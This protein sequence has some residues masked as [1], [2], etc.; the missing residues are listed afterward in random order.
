MFE[1]SYDFLSI[2]NDFGKVGF[3]PGVCIVRKVQFRANCERKAGQ[4]K[5]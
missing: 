2:Q 4:S 5:Y 1:M 3:W